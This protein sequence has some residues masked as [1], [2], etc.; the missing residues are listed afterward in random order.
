MPSYIL[1]ILFWNCVTYWPKHTEL[2]L[3]G[4]CNVPKLIHDI[5]LNV[6]FPSCFLNGFPSFEFWLEL[7]L[8]SPVSLCPL[9]WFS[10]SHLMNSHLTTPNIHIFH[11]ILFFF[12]FADSCV[13]L[14]QNFDGNLTVNIF[15]ETKKVHLMAVLEW[16]NITHD[17]HLQMYSDH[18]HKI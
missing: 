10:S 4:E 3:W 9:Q 8:T 15:E 5:N 1:A 14:A 2:K 16:S 13:I 17:L 11:N 7:S 12:F 6:I 18:C